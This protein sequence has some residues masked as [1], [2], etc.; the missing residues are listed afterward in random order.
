MRAYVIFVK[1]ERY[2][3]M[4]EIG[5]TTAARRGCL[6]TGKKKKPRR[7]RVGKNRSSCRSRTG[8]I[9]KE[10]GEEIEEEGKENNNNRK[11]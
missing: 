5:D 8:K 6:E 4:R 9:E 7:G 2:G 1:S 10:E 11:K 3:M